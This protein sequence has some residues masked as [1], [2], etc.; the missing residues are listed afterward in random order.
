MEYPI[1]K[2]NIIKQ[3]NRH[4]DNKNKKKLCLRV[5][6][7]GSQGKSRGTDFREL[8]ANEAFM[9]QLWD[10]QDPQYE[11]ITASEM[12]GHGKFD[13]HDFE[14]RTGRKHKADWFRMLI[15]LPDQTQRQ[16]ILLIKGTS[17]L[18][19]KFLE[20]LHKNPDICL[21][22]RGLEIKKTSTG[23]VTFMDSIKITRYLGEI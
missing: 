7:T 18:I 11:E 20:V 23:Q 5:E 17:Q 3:E 2:K 6:N 1:S 10:E 9:H 14:I 4:N 21:P 19:I 15:T 13:L 22:L 8:L 16:R 12:I